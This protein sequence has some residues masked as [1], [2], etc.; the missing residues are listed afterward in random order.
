MTSRIVRWRAGRSRGPSPKAPSVALRRA[1][2]VAGLMTARRAAANSMARGS[3]SNCWHRPATA[4]A[5]A[6]EKNEAGLA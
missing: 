2:S 1:K 3:P 6:S 4:A 5:L